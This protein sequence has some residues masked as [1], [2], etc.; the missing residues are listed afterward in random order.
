MSWCASSLLFQHIFQHV[1]HRKDTYKGNCILSP[2]CVS[3]MIFRTM[4]KEAFSSFI[5]SHFE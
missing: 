2:N 1:V 4:E 3:F 5:S